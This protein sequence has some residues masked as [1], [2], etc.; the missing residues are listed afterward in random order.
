VATAGAAFLASVWPRQ[1][2]PAWEPTE[3]AREHPALRV[4]DTGTARACERA[5]N[6]G[7][8][9]LPPG[10]RV[11]PQWLAFRHARA[12]D[13]H[14]PVWA[15][16]YP[17]GAIGYRYMVASYAAM[18]Q[19]LRNYPLEQ[20]HAFEIVGADDTPGGVSGRPPP[21][22]VHFYMDCEALLSLNPDFDVAAADAALRAAVRDTFRAAYNIDTDA[23]AEAEWRVLDASNAKKVSRHY[24]V[25]LTGGRRFLDSAH[26]GAMLRRVLAHVRATR[27]R[28]SPLW[29]R[30]PLS[31]DDAEG[32]PP[33]QPD[34][35]RPF[36]E[37]DAGLT[38]FMDPGVYTTRRVYRTAFSCKPGGGTPLLPLEWRAAMARGHP[39]PN[40]TFAVWAHHLVRYVPP[41]EP[42]T[43]VL[44]AREA[45]GDDPVS[46]THADVTRT[47]AMVSAAAAVRGGAIPDASPLARVGGGGGVSRASVVGAQPLPA[48]AVG[49]AVIDAAAKLIM[50]MFRQQLYSSRSYTYVPGAHLDV[51]V[52]AHECEILRAVTR[53]PAAA[54]KHNNVLW[55]INLRRCT[56]TQRCHAAACNAA[57]ARAREVRFAALDKR[58]RLMREAH[59]VIGGGARADDELPA[60]LVP[61]HPVP[62][63]LMRPLA[64]ALAHVPEP[65]CDPTTI[66]LAWMAAPPRPARLD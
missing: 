7:G 27:G 52:L 42:V 35:G 12:G 2:V 19:W 50:G 1:P 28:D 48:G 34:P 16:S 47:R 10:G 62:D 11:S 39:M 37:V 25:A 5:G 32:Q 58:R 40:P 20:W 3:R 14:L 54:H 60:H 64:A 15:L 55:R 45:N 46:T 17:N 36:H 23:A 22:Y 41:G 51:A 49:N 66:L 65:E 61:E 63:A 26:A 31:P 18:F 30:G 59:T 56:V 33:Q 24:V 9:P 4:F 38:S 44:L 13:A 43:C 21:N 6:V 53:D 57:L 29:V 8:A